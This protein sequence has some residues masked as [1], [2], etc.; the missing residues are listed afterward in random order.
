SYEQNHHLGMLFIAYSGTRQRL[1]ES[2]TNAPLFDAIREGR[3]LGRA[4]AKIAHEDVEA[5]MCEDIDAARKRLNIGE[6][7]IYR[8]CIAQ[9]IEE[10]LAD[11]DMRLPEQLAA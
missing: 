3:A 7:V 1:K 6:P 2:K 8:R 4:A 10:G 5:L 11:S 9:L